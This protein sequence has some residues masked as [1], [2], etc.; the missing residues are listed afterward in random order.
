V[1]QVAPTPPPP[2]A[3]PSGPPRRSTTPYAPPPPI[4]EQARQP[5]PV[6][7]SAYAPV[8]N[9][10]YAPAQSSAYAPEEADSVPPIAPPAA[11]PRGPPSRPSSSMAAPRQAQ[12]APSYNAFDPPL[13][14]QTLSRASMKAAQPVLPPPQ[15]S[16]APSFALSPPSE[17]VAQFDGSRPPSRAATFEAPPRPSSRAAPGFEA[18]PPAGPPRPSSRAASGYEA[19][20]PGPPRPS[21]RATSTKF[22]APPTGPPRPPSRAT[23]AFEAPPPGPPRRSA[24][25]FQPPPRPPSTTQQAPP[26]QP[27]PL[28]HALNPEAEDRYGEQEERL[29]PPVSSFAIPQLHSGTEPDEEGGAWNNDEEDEYQGL[30]S[31][32]EPRRPYENDRQVNDEPEDTYSRPPAR[33]EHDS[34]SSEATY[35]PAPARSGYSPVQSQSAS[36]DPYGP[37]QNEAPTKESRSD[38]RHASNYDSAPARSG[39]SPVQSGYSPQSRKASYDPYGP[40]QH[41]APAEDAGSSYAPPSA[42]SGYSP[43]KQHTASY[44][45]YGPGQHDVPAKEIDSSYAPPPARSGYSPVK[46]HTASY[47]PY[48]PGRHDA[49]TTRNAPPTSA[50]YN[51]YAP[52]TLSPRTEPSSLGLSSLGSTAPGQNTYDSPYAPARP[53]G[54]QYTPGADNHLRVASPGTEY[55][56]SP[57]ANNYFSAI[58][59]GP[60][61]QT[62][63]PQQ[64]LEQRPISEDP[65]GRS[66]LAARNAPIAIFGFGGVLITAFP[67]I[68]NVQNEAA[69]GHAR[70]A[71][72]GYASGRGQLWI[73]SVSDLV[74]ESALKSNETVFPGPLVLDPS[75]AKGAAGDKK[76]KEAV[77]AYL[78]ARVDE[79]EMGLPYLKT[80]ANATRREQE[81]KLVLLRLL[82]AMI[83]GEGK[84][85][86][87]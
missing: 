19:P 25:S 63:T 84:L 81:G 58:A 29:T 37:G 26:R 87:R 15:K 77:L 85:T 3:P 6:Q 51:P 2:A 74:S 12:R 40:G 38:D 46:Q 49:S 65:L 27:S 57:P 23:P 16:P 67:G 54:D 41:D 45:P 53:A 61:D 70:T 47:D 5:T 62:Y 39:Y 75:S 18:P 17:N 7:S 42:R 36:Y 35:A 60:A 10:A 64:V 4:V 50:P 59:P 1:A 11:P 69:G 22:E 9:S 82:L 79:T 71:S 30:G 13:R 33:Q 21:S 83:V 24:S 86:G 14:T 76:K 56:T 20:Q 43:V 66:T 32:N 52:S 55:G 48:G 28:A 8:Q 34:S 73:R 31:G 44:D 68:A 78:K 80:S 72:Y